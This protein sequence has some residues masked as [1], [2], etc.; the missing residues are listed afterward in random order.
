[1][2]TIHYCVNEWWLISGTGDCPSSQSETRDASPTTGSFKRVSSRSLTSIGLPVPNPLFT[3]SDAPLHRQIDLH[4]E[5]D[6]E[7][8]PEKATNIDFGAYVPIPTAV[9]FASTEDI[10]LEPS[11]P[12]FIP[13]SQVPIARSELASTSTV[14]KP[15]VKLNVKL[16]GGGRAI[17]PITAEEIRL[18][19]DK[20]MGYQQD[21][22]WKPQARPRNMH[23]PVTPARPSSTLVPAQDADK[24]INLQGQEENIDFS[25]LV[26]PSLGFTYSD[27]M[28]MFM[29]ASQVPIDQSELP[30]TSI[31]TK[32]T[33][34]L[35]IQLAGGAGGMKPLTEEDIKVSV[36]KLMAYQEDTK[37]KPQVRTRLPPLVSGSEVASTQTGE[38]SNSK[39]DIT[40]MDDSGVGL[41]EPVDGLEPVDPVVNL[42]GKGKQRSVTPHGMSPPRSILRPMENLNDPG[43][44]DNQNDVYQLAGAAPGGSSDDSIIPQLP[45][46]RKLDNPFATRAQLVGTPARSST[47]SFKTPVRPTPASRFS[48]QT[49][50]EPT[51]P[52]SLFSQSN[53]SVSSQTVPSTLYRLGLSQRKPKNKS[54]GFTTPFKPG[55][56][57]GEK[58]R[59][60][61]RGTPVRKTG[62]PTPLRGVT[63]LKGGGNG[64]V[65]GI[66]GIT[67]ALEAEKERQ[68]LERA[69]FDTRKWIWS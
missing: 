25:A 66:S 10:L 48:I 11:L 43:A 1:M 19:A 40:N 53:T 65:T 63:P 45:L 13:A 54:S 17:K 28:P 58:G 29:P 27:A 32:S 22:K 41:L 37:W 30:S 3:E 35:N 56:A 18:S 16:A 50:S 62:I 12:M 8:V 21:T 38:S 23:P 31:S 15:T 49:S 5:V 44:A 34:K 20:L 59:E 67:R 14:S 64:A 52:T 46:P 61:L 2:V 36:E 51:A 26:K 4:P 24:D 69:V 47:A 7:D 55:M 39:L 33:K 9:G 6:G 42:K 68:M 57:P 60:T